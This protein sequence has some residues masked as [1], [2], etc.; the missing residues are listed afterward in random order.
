MG[1]N[2]AGEQVVGG[3]R[4]SIYSA[5]TALR[6]AIYASRARFVFSTR[7][8]TWLFYIE[9]KFVILLR[10]SLEIMVV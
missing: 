8:A 7:Q 6:G 10:G 1:G 4:W 9:A 3:E 5:I 2:V